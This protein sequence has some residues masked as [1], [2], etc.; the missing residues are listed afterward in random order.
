[1]S[2]ARSLVPTFTLTPAAHQPRGGEVT[3]RPLLELFPA[4]STA[5]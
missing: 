3:A 4:H 5:R 2:V 1:M